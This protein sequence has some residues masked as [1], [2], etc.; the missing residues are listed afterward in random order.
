LE[1]EIGAKPYCVVPDRSM[2][3]VSVRVLGGRGQGAGEIKAVLEIAR[4]V[5][6]TRHVF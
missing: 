3:R 2:G 5:A 6:L 1:L 4:I